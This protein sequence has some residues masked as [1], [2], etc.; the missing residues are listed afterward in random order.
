MKKSLLTAIADGG[1]RLLDVGIAP[2]PRTVYVYTPDHRLTAPS[3]PVADRLH[4][5]RDWR[6]VA[7]DLAVALHRYEAGGLDGHTLRSTP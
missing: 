5:Q 7:G 2:R 4:L 3:S 1:A 6:N